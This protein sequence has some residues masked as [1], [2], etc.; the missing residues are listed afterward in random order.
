MPAMRVCGQEFNEDI[1]AQ[2][3]TLVRGKPDLSRSALS[4]EVCEWLDWRDPRG[5]PRQ[6]S[7]RKALA[8]L[9]KSGQLVL[10]PTAKDFSFQRRTAATDSEVQAPPSVTGDL[11]SL[12][13]VTLTLVSSRRSLQARTW[14]A[15]MR[16]YHYLGAGPLCG[17]QLRYLIHS[18]RH[19]WVGA[20]SF[21]AAAW[22]VAARDK[23]IEWSAA[24]RERNLS[25]VV[26]N[27]R[28]LIA[29]TVRVKNLASHA[30]GLAVERLAADWRARYGYD[31]V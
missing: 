16:D 27:S 17:A 22:S 18:E 2:I 21:S 19:G 4:R 9:H 30:L 20:L 8:Q 24:A 25:R 15:W 14:K 1:L 6:M 12:G 11:A 28:F 13:R 7:C 31:P 10:S 3:R 5:K 29:P 23:H 26:C